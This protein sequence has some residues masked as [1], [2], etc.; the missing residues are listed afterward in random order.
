MLL[1]LATAAAAAAL[2]A[3]NTAVA[4]GVSTTSA[5]ADELPAAVMTAGPVVESTDTGDGVLYRCCSNTAQQQLCDSCLWPANWPEA[6][7]GMKHPAARLQE[8]GPCTIEQHIGAYQQY[9]C[10]CSLVT[11]CVGL[12]SLLHSLACHSGAGSGEPQTALFT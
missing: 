4:A 3:A 10:C 1:P 6:R 8:A 7:L 12:S 5:A 9:G 2:T 11:R